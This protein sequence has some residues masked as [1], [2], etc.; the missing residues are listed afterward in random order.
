M[1]F[2]RSV[3]TLAS[4]TFA[5]HLVVVVATPLLTRIYSPDDFG[6]FA[7]FTAL[8]SVVLVV[9]SLRYEFAIPL[10][11]STDSAELLFRAAL[12]MNALIAFISL[13]FIV[14]F[15]SHISGLLGAPKL[16]DYLLF[17][18][19]AVLCAGAYKV[20]NY[21]A[22]RRGD[23]RAIGRSK[24]LQGVSMAGAQ[25]SAG[26]SGLGVAGL[27]IGQAVGQAAGALLLANLGG[28]RRHS[29][30]HAASFKRVAVLLRKHR[31]FPTYDMPA[32]AVDAV[33]A[34]LPNMLLLTLFNPGVAGF[35]MLGERVIS[36]PM[37][38]LGQAVGQVLFSET[39]AAIDDG[40]LERLTR[41]VAL[42]LGAIIV[43]PTL[44]V[45]AVAEDVFGW[46]FG[47]A[48]RDAGVYA[49]WLVLGQAVQFVYSPI[50]LVLTATSGQHMNFVI[51]VF[52]LIGRSGALLYGYHAGSALYAIIG[53]S[54][55]SAIV[56]AMAI[57]LVLRHVRGVRSSNGP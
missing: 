17:L 55:I 3:A 6:L 5:S 8:M 4:T 51:Q 34:Q 44:I 20:L 57:G 16:G 1:R 10:P 14:L 26:L 29:R 31:R 21:W 46:I 45:F 28:F 25:L 39:R 53:L 7:L 15:N 54:V 52:M 40:S 11:K 41:R 30:S 2:L 27:I 35:Y 24:I 50:S 22:I 33:S 13:P 56:Y 43:L 36:T 32:A 37:S 49:G 38:M 23:F 12:I 18:P 19:I 47:V 42:N 9:S 48:W